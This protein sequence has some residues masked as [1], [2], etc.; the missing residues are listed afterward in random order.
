[1][2]ALVGDNGAGKST[3]TK[4]L[5]GAI[6]PD[7]G[8][9]AYW[10]EPVSVQSIGHALEL[11]VHTVYQDLALAPDL[12]VAENMFLGRE[13]ARSGIAGRVRARGRRW[14]G[15]S[16][17]TTRVPCPPGRRAIPPN[18]RPFPG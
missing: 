13:P 8:T 6:A 4:I 12:S 9:L 15:S 10:G 1:M 14:P 11:G 17:S 18:R 7:S 2:L 3:L 5:C 16:T